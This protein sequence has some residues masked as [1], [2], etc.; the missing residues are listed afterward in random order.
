MQIQILTR[1]TYQ[2]GA[3]YMNFGGSRI[4]YGDWK[5]T[6]VFEHW[7]NRSGDFNYHRWDLER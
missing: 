7:T 2:D 1:G 4:G 3:V 6:R 5:T